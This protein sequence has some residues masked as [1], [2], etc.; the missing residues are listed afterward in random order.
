[1][2]RKTRH[3]EKGTATCGKVAKALNR[4]SREIQ[5]VGRPNANKNNSKN[6]LHNTEGRKVCVLGTHDC[7]FYDP[8]TSRTSD[9][10]DSEATSKQVEGPS[11]EV[12]KLIKLL[13]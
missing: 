5:Q 12:D 6:T 10:K 13:T 8:L 11:L 9:S 1:M 2:S 7:I 4:A 3:I